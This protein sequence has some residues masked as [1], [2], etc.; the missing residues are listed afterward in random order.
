MPVINKIDLPSADPDRVRRKLRDVIGFRRTMLGDFTKTG[1]NVDQVLEQIV[2]LVPPP[3]GN[4]DA[5]SKAY[6]D[7][8]TM[9]TGALSH[10]CGW[11]TGGSIRAIPSV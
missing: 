9:P 10:M 6:F 3:G 5:R 2:K 11:R 8:I 7:S 1:Q 4:G